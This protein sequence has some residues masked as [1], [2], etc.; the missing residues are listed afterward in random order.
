MRREGRFLGEGVVDEV[1][2]DGNIVWV[3]LAQ[4]FGRILILADEGIELWRS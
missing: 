2:A 3:H 1:T 4:G